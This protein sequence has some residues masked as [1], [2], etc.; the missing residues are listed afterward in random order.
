MKK[1][2]KC[3]LISDLTKWDLCYYC[4]SGYIKKKT[5]TSSSH[6]M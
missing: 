4:W 2:I 5:I 3:K 6:N 1:C